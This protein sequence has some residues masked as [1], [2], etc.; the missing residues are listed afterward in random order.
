MGWFKDRVVEEEDATA[1]YLTELQAKIT[2]ATIEVE[3]EGE[4]ITFTADTLVEPLIEE[5][6]N[7]SSCDSDN[8]PE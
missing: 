4:F 3:S 6:E 1:F 2:N 7:G 8:I 5:D